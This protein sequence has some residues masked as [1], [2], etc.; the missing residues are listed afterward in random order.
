MQSIKLQQTRNLEFQLRLA[1]FKMIN[2]FE[3]QLLFSHCLHYTSLRWQ[4]LCQGWVTSPASHKI[5]R[6]RWRERIADR[7]WDTAAGT[8]TLALD[9]RVGQLH[10]LSWVRRR[11]GP[12]LFSYSQPW[13][14]PSTGSN[15][16]KSLILCG[17]DNPPEI[18]AVNAIN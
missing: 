7:A 2:E 4:N 13:M 3:T 1:S 17:S 6:M 5:K 16:Y 14:G 10:L 9:R 8:V 15:F 11:S 18:A 12:Q